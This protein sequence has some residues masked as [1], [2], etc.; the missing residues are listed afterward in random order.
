MSTVPDP[1]PPPAPKPAPAPPTGFYSAA[2]SMARTPLGFLGLCL[3]LVY[4]IAGLV[5]AVNQHLDKELAAV[6]VWFIVLYPVLVL[7]TFVVLI[8]FFRDKLIWPTDFTDPKDFNAFEKMAREALDRSRATEKKVDVIAEVAPVA[9]DWLPDRE[10]GAAGAAGATAPA[11]DDPQKGKWGGQRAAGGYEVRAGKITALKSDPDYF[12]VPLT[13]GRTD[14]RPVTGTVTFHL[15]DS[16]DPDVDEVEAEDGV[17]ELE[18]VGY[19]AFT[20]GVELPD[21]TKL[22][23]D[24]SDPDIAA[25]AKFKAR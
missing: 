21:G 15:H 16:F 9:F 6:L 10:A 23:L 5:F 8:A 24:L 4:A 20:A 19:G 22:E 25:P 17:A 18:V 7:V 13:V 2:T 12:R 1:P 3:V 14:G 11:T